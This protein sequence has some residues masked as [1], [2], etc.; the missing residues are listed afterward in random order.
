[1]KT[2]GKLMKMSASFSSKWLNECHD[3]E[4]K[5]EITFPF[6]YLLNSHLSRHNLN[7]LLNNIIK[8][9]DNGHR[10]KNDFDRSTI[11]VTLFFSF[12]LRQYSQKK[13]S[14]FWPQ[15]TITLINKWTKRKIK[16]E[17][18]RLRGEKKMFSCGFVWNVY[19]KSQ[20]TANRRN[21]TNNQP[22]KRW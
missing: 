6:F 19:M 4:W 15:H 12:V 7:A 10:K 5:T 3:F 14:F 11:S 13:T 21:N 20:K 9:T 22:T 1:M 18:K 8:F 17:I 16:R 2:N